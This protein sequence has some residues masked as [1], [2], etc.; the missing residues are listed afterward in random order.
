MKIPIL[1][2]IA[3]LAL[4][5]SSAWAENLE[6]E[7]A[8]SRIQVDAKATGHAFTGELKNYT[9]KVSGNAQTNVPTA[10]SLTWEFNDLKTGDEKRDKEMIR[11]L[12]GGNPKGSFAFEKSWV[13]DKGQLHAQGELTI[14][15]V[16]KTVSF[17]YSV[18]REGDHVTIDGTARLD[19]QNFKLPIIRTMAI[20]TVDPKL[21]VRFHIVGQLK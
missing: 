2:M 11:W 4:G 21:A 18:K 13:D 10:F 1:K 16:S 17:P 6:V 19:Y 9:V 3:I 5:V 14:H 7:K 8:D 20:M 12:G 15:G